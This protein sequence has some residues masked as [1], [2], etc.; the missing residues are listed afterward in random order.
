[1]LENRLD[2]IYF[3]NKCRM[4]F[5]FHSDTEDHER[6]WGHTQFVIVQLEVDMRE[7]YK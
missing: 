4:V 1:M 5:L 3:C 2:K 6:L 7:H